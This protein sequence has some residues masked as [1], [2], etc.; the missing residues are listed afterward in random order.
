MRQIEYLYFFSI[1]LV[2]VRFPT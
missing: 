1:K 2:S